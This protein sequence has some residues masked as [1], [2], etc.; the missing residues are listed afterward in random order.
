MAKGSATR[1]SSTRKRSPALA[2]KSLRVRVGMRGYLRRVGQRIRVEVIED[3][4]HIGV[5]G[6]K[7]L[8]VRRVTRSVEPDSGFEVPAEEFEPVEAAAR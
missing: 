6:R 5:G 4:G 3:R 8:R 2:K 1:K 7:L